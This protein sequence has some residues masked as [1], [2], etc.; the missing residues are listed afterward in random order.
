MIDDDCDFEIEIGTLLNLSVFSVN[1]Y[2]H[3]LA[4]KGYCASIRLEEICGY[5]DEEFF[6]SFLDKKIDPEVGDL[7]W[8]LVFEFEEG[9]CNWFDTVLLLGNVTNQFDK[10]VS[11]VRAK[12]HNFEPS[13]SFCVLK[14][15]EVAFLEYLTY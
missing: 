9:C 13:S 11:H 8:G 14:S 4:L 7:L 1:H 5:A 10:D 15:D 12:E 2:N 6:N 3:T